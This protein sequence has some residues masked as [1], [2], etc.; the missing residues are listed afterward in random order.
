MSGKKKNAKQKNRNKIA[1]IP[2][3]H[4]L[5]CGSELNGNYCHMCG[6]QATTVKPN[7]KSFVL[8]YIYN[9]YIWDPKFFKTLKY[10]ICRPG[11][12]TNEFL[13]GKYASYVHPL[14]LNMF[15]LFVFITLFAL[16]SGTKKMNDSIQVFTKDERVL[17]GMQISIIKNDK[18][19]E[20]KLMASPRDTVLLVAPEFIADEYPQYISKLKTIESG[21]SNYADKWIASVPHVLIEDNIIIPTSDDYYCFNTETGKGVEL[22]ELLNSVWTQMVD[23]FTRYFPMLVLLTVPFF[24]FS[25]RIV[26]HKRKCPKINHFVFSLHYTALLE[27]LIILIFLLHLV[28]KPPMEILQWVLLLISCAY[29]TIAFRQVYK[30]DSW[31]KSSIKAM[32]TTVIYLTIIFFVFVGIFIVACCTIACNY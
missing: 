28:V 13:S 22:L 11:H 18:E 27:L 16:F 21:K 31:F 23:F 29:L 26:H 6:Q 2:Y 5:N 14:K 3:K 17:S 19:Y 1:D 24:A 32:L 7:V 12:I 25:L 9:A 15:I 30:S 4:C 20:E 8:E 10:L